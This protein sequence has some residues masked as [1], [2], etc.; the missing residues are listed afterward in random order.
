MNK[1]NNIVR[2]LIGTDP[3]VTAA[4]IKEEFQRRVFSDE[5]SVVFYTDL[6]MKID[7]P[8]PSIPLTLRPLTASDDVSDL[9]VVH[10]GKL[11]SMELKTR[12]ECLL[13]LKSGIST[14][15]GGFTNDGKLVVIVWLISRDMNDRIK[16]YFDDGI[17][18]LGPDEVLCEFIFTHQE[19]R[20]M[21]L[22]TWATIQMFKKAREIGAVKALAYVN[23]K[24]K[25][26]IYVTRRFGW[27]PFLVKKVSRRL[28]RRKI[29]FYPYSDNMKDVLD[30]TV[31]GNMSE[32][33]KRAG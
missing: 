2:L 8:K 1:W 32:V 23:I 16:L 10:S 13:F 19:Y 21:K 33:N 12:V 18:L 30:A 5:A 7:I 14:C 15:Y 25:K 22:H 28:F 3:R 17:K 31:G 20:G 11:D 24:N 6:N 9:L 26:S 4:F 27:E 29:E